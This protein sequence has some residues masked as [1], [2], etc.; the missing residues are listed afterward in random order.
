MAAFADVNALVGL[1]EANEWE[2]EISRRAAEVG[3]SE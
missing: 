3:D 2:V 1:P